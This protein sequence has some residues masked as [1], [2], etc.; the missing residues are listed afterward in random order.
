ME[1]VQ[2]PRSNP[3]PHHYFLDSTTDAVGGGV[4]LRGARTADAWV[5]AATERCLSYS[6][7]RTRPTMIVKRTIEM[8]IS[9]QPSSSNVLCSDYDKAC[10]FHLCC[11]SSAMK[12]FTSSAWGFVLRAEK[13][14]AFRSDLDSHIVMDSSN[15]F[16][17]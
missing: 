15:S 16:N 13:G 3:S 7:Q 17:L 14:R 2:Q 4:Q 11:S 5:V 9:V 12:L 6:G 10:D 1:D 8:I